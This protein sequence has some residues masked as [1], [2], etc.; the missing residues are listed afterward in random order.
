MSKNEASIS[1]VTR[2]REAAR[3]SYDRMS[4]WYD[5]LARPSEKKYTEL[6]LRMLSVQEGE[7]VIEI[8][9]GTGHA[10]VAL[11]QSVGN[12][13]RVYGVDISEGML[14]VAL[15]RVERAGLGARVDLRRGDAVSLP[16]A[17]SMFDAIFVS[18]TLELFDTPD[19][20]VVLSECR[21]V[22]KPGGRICVVALSRRG[23]AGVMVRLYEWAH[24]KFPNAVDCRPIYV[25][26]AL[27]DAGF[28]VADSTAMS[29][30]GL[31]L[32][33]VLAERPCTPPST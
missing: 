24:A 16:F 22:L 18:F 26:R 25:Q 28:H 29:M 14:G 30:W 17:A 7:T 11:A 9:F 31:P 15:A 8:G 5:L 10:V 3:A 1:R 23:R 19:I 4:G 13:G 2:A 27:E 21:R 6:G 32:E 12:S 20:P 33:V